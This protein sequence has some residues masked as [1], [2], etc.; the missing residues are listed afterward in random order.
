MFFGAAVR[1]LSS[2]SSGGHAVALSGESSIGGAGGTGN[3]CKVPSSFKTQLRSTKLKERSCRD[4]AANSERKINS[5]VLKIGEC[6]NQSVNLFLN[7]DL[8]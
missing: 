3:S 8:P 4:T 7:H 1:E 2:A 6:Y 5:G